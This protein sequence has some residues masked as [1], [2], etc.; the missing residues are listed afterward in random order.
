MCEQRRGGA[1]GAARRVLCV[2]SLPRL[3]RL[4][5]RRCCC[6][7]LPLRCW[8][9]G[10]SDRAAHLGAGAPQS[11]GPVRSVCSSPAPEH[12]G[13]ASPPERRPAALPDDAV[14]A[15]GEAEAR[16]PPCRRRARKGQ[17]A[18]KL[19]CCGRDARVPHRCPT[20]R[21]ALQRLA[22]RAA[23]SPAAK[24]RGRGRE[25]LTGPHVWVAVLCL[26]EHLDPA[27]M[28][29]WCAGGRV[30]AEA[31]QGACTW[32]RRGPWAAVRR[33]G[34]WGRTPPCTGTKRAALRPHPAQSRASP[35]AA[36][37]RVP[38]GAPAPKGWARW[39]PLTTVSLRCSWPGAP[40]AAALCAG[41]LAGPS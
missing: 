21:G 26:Q 8:L 22:G 40:A 3:S 39:L 36:R 2:A 5:G 35:G 15:G 16:H 6:L 11:S 14:E 9:A 38:G 7:T 10:T 20:P 1:R 12:V 31:P 24:A 30:S 33:T 32:Q 18:V 19:R 4:L 27:A 17:Q 13:R 41:Y 23:S 34:G 29:R 37:P 25:R 28:R